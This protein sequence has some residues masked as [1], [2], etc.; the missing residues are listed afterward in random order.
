LGKREECRKGRDD[1]K[2]YFAQAGCKGGQ[3]SDKREEGEGEALG[4]GAECVAPW[5]EKGDKFW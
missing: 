1:V 2:T 5:R 3:K 4:R